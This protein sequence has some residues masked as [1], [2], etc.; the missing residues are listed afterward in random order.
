LIA[1]VVIALVLKN[2]AIPDQAASKLKQEQEKQKLP[3]VFWACW[4]IV[5]LVVSVEWL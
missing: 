5:I 2:T 3:P 1:L 4:V